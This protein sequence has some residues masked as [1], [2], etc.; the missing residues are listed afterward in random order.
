MS[1]TKIDSLTPQQEIQLVKHREEY[2]KW[3][4]CC[5]PI[6]KEL[7]VVQFKL[8]HRLFFSLNEFR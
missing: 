6:N 3:G 7:E 1:P 5:E 2:L 8:Y 4:L